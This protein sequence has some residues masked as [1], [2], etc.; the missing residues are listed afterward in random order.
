[1]LTEGTETE[2]RLVAL[3][4]EYSDLLDRELIW[5]PNATPIGAACWPIFDIRVFNFS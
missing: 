4:A 2:R 5:I 3:V 1:M